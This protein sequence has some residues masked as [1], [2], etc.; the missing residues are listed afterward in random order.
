ME[1]LLSIYSS[2]WKIR[3]LYNFNSCE[4]FIILSFLSVEGFLFR[5]FCFF[6]Q[7]AYLTFDNIRL[8]CCADGLEN[9]LEVLLIEGT[10]AYFFM[11]NGSMLIFRSRVRDRREFPLFF[12]RKSFNRCLTFC[13]CV[14][15]GANVIYFL[16]ILL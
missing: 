6:F 7:L 14:F 13:V 8:N 9:D 2:P 4:L 16:S 1:N 10:T 15:L 11:V 3:L 12:L 5:D